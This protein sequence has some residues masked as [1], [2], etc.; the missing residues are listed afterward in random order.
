ME[1]GM[2]RSDVGGW[3]H[4]GAGV[5]ALALVAGCATGASSQ[6][7][8]ASSSAQLSPAQPAAEQAK[9]EQDR[10]AILSMVGDYDVDFDFQETV[11]FVPGYELHK[12]QRSG[13]Y[14]VVRVI[15]DS[16][17]F[18][19][20]QHI[21]V[22]GGDEKF[23]IKHWRQDWRYEP[24]K[25]LVFIGGNAWETRPVP[26]AQ[27]AGEWSQTVYQVEDSPRY[28]AVGMWKHDN[29]V[30][31]WAG[32]AEWRP[33]PRRDATK[34]DDYDAILAVNRHAITPEGWVHEQD[35]S[36][37]VLRGDQPQVLVREVGVNTY[38]HYDG[39]PAEIAT[40]YWDATKDYWA[41]VREEWSRLEA[42]ESGFGLTVQGEPEPLYIP[43]L[44]LADKIQSGETT[45]EAAIAQAKAVIAGL[46]T[47]APGSLHDRI[48]HTSAAGS[49]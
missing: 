22:V 15:E 3:R 27:R 20:L 44:D 41:G 31:E 17:D 37:L 8:G 34:R 11:A 49:K 2:L 13:G 16:G 43:L 4:F 21:L 26:E 39:F 19:S 46:T 28:G 1:N 7:S 14:E 6:V 29:G 10:Q 9:F 33:L 5:L 36:K 25:V 35:N 24:E 47:T 30:S 23:P 38:R 40:Q 42:S 32:Q 48:G 45:T 18:I 12:P